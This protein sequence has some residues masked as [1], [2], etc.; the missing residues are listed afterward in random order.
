V[1]VGIS[2]DPLDEIQRLRDES[3]QKNILV[4]ASEAKLKEVAS[5]RND[6]DIYDRCQCGLVMDSKLELLN[7]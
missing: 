3:N 6:P 2:A 5:A 1:L 4:I 7:H